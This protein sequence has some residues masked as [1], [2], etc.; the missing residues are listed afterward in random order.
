MSRT[1]I[2]QTLFMPPST[3][4]TPVLLFLPEGVSQLLNVLTAG[5]FVTRATRC[6]VTG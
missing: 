2:Q 4:P 5:A 3:D 1:N 6:S